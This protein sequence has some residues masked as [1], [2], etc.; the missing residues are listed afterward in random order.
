MTD[1]PPYLGTDRDELEKTWY[2]GKGVYAW[3]A[4]TN[5]KRVGRRYIATALVFF[6]IAGILAV[7]FNLVVY[8]FVLR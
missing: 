4:S 5:H 3:L 6:V 2:D 8:Y 7:V 1:L